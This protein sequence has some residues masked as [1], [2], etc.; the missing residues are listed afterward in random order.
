MKNLLPLKKQK[1]AIIGSGPAGLMAATCLA[2][3][4]SL[5]VHL[6]EKRPGLGRKLLIA[7]S[8]GLNISHELNEEDWLRHYEGGSRSL[9]KAVFEN[10]GPKAWIQFIEQELQMETF[11]GTSDRYFVREMKAS[12]LLKRWSEYL[13]GLGVQIHPNHELVDFYS[14]GETVKLFFDGKQESVLVDQAAFFL[15]GASWETSEPHWIPL[16]QKKGIALSTFEASNVGYELA[17]TE[18]FLKEAEGKPLKKIKFSSSRGSKLGELVVTRYGLEG[19]PIYFYGKPGEV[20]LDLKPDLDAEMILKKL[21]QV[22]E[23]LSPIRRVKQKLDLNEAALALIF[24]F[25]KPDT[26]NDLEKLVQ[27]IKNFP[28]QLLRPRPLEEAISS[29]G[30]VCFENLKDSFELKKFPH[31]F[32]GGEMLD[33][34]APTGGFLIQ[35]CVSQGAWVARK[36]IEKTPR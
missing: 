24:H 36:I 12:G 2:R 25:T 19:T 9:W 1:I 3:N 26:K 8:S 4:K 10:Y 5:E 13:R 34:D 16:F 31:V 20:F 30:G 27:Q 33:W 18:A 29:K 32:C 22:K 23:N 28:L 6:F 14:E 35:A 21:N 17:W 15:G 11:L 7:G